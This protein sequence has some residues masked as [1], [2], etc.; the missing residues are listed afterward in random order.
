MDMRIVYRENARVERGVTVYGCT[1]RTPVIPDS[2][3]VK[4]ARKLVAAGIRP[5]DIS[6]AKA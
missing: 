3:A 4:Y 2:K 1:R 6:F 5:G